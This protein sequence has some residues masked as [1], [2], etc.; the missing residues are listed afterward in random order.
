LGLFFADIF[1]KL[2]K[3]FAALTRR[4]R[5]RVNAGMDDGQSLQDGG[6][7]AGGPRSAPDPKPHVKD[8]RPQW[9]A[10]CQWWSY[11]KWLTAKSARLPSLRIACE[12]EKSLFSGRIKIQG[13]PKFCFLR[14]P[15]SG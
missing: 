1:S 3:Q 8:H 7:F 6:W 15:L 10:G 9:L 14:N 13:V 11:A 2:V 12:I 5:S 4:S